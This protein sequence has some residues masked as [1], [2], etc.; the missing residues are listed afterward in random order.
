VP[1]RG[2]APRCDTSRRGSAGDGP[3]WSR[4]GPP[5][6]GPL[7][8]GPSRGG[9][10]GDGPPCSGLP[11]GGSVSSRDGPPPGGAPRRGSAGDGPLARR[12]GGPGLSA[13]PPLPAACGFEPGSAG[14]R[15][16]PGSPGC[17]YE[18]GSPGCP[19][20]PG[21][22][23]LARRGRA[24]SWGWSRPGPAGDRGADWPRGGSTRR[25]PAEPMARAYPSERLTSCGQVFSWTP[26]PHSPAGRRVLPGTRGMDGATVGKANA[27]P[28][29]P[30]A[31]H[32]GQRHLTPASGTLPRPAARHVT[33]GQPGQ[34]AVLGRVVRA[35]LVL[36][37]LTVI[38]WGRYP[39]S[40]VH[41]YPHARGT[42][43]AG[44][45]TRQRMRDSLALDDHPGAGPRIRSHMKV[46]DCAHFQPQGR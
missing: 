23:G 26:S 9:V 2:G 44:L 16:E 36:L 7:R 5:P 11:R 39:C 20:E 35:R 22:A 4:C 34:V 31:P 41:A 27:R 3:V 40:S 30:R 45:V 1:P 29:R 15:Y 12:R 13:G 33:P 8:C 42:R 24:T 6:G 14:C 46:Y 18:P 19:Y 25:P 10:S 32:P 21:S 38:G 28:H 43:S 37:A 17:G